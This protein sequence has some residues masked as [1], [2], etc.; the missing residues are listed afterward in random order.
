[1][2]QLRW[3]LTL[4]QFADDRSEF[5]LSVGSIQF[6]KNGFSIT[7]DS[8]ET[9]ANGVTVV[10]R[11]GNPKAISLST[12]TAEFEVQRPILSLREV[13]EKDPITIYFSDTL[14]VGKAQTSI[15]SVAAGGSSA[16]RVLI[17]GVKGDL[18]QYSVRITLSGVR[19]QYLY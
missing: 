15:G 12:V 13:F 9:S 17:P 18:D 19:Y 16:F 1:I 7:L 3:Q 6:M 2:K 4:H 10:G 5:T 14:T 8:V 11:F